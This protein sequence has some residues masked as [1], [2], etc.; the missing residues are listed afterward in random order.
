[1]KNFFLSSLA[2]VLFLLCLDSCQKIS[3]SLSALMNKAKASGQGA[4]S[5]V[6][7]NGDSTLYSQP[8]PVDTANKMI[9]SYLTSID[10]PDSNS[11]IRSWAFNADT[12]RNYLNSINGRHIRYVK[13]FMA[14]TLAYINSGHYGERPV[15][16][17][18][19]DFTIVIVGVDSAGGYVLSGTAMPY[20][21]SMPCP[22]HCVAKPLIHN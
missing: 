13:F 22:Y 11:E 12:L 10:Y 17:D 9:Q 2:F 15:K 7:P 14:H 6:F 18:A 1:M 16:L 19:N 8:I 20:D 4:G 5:P 3:S 21:Q